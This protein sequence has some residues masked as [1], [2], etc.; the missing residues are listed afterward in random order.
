MTRLCKGNIHALLAVAALF[1]GNSLARSQNPPAE[2]HTEAAVIADDDAWGKAESSGDA[3]YV[4]NLLLP[5][6]RSISPDGSVHPKSAILASANK[7][8]GSAQNTAEV[9]KWRAEHPTLTSVVINGDVAILTFTLNRPG[10]PNLVLSSDIF[11]YRD[12]HWHAIY[13]QHS[14]AG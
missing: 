10:S 1:A 7:H 12:G 8:T 5:E 14:T 6:Y 11:L 2:P 9:E 13:S 4:D 3:A